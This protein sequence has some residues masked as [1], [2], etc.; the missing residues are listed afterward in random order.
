MLQG[1][2]VGACGDSPADSLVDEITEGSEAVAQR[3]CGRPVAT[4]HQKRSCN[5]CV[6]G[7]G[8]NKHLTA[9]LRAG[10]LFQTMA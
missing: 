4:R 1:G 2:A 6:K 9:R 10:T 8:T 5:Y 3:R 7:S